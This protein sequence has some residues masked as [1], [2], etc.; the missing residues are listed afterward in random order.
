M[1][2]VLQIKKCPFCGNGLVPVNTKD[3]VVSA[4]MLNMGHSKVIYFILFGNFI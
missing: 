1:K 3:R 2:P 4:K